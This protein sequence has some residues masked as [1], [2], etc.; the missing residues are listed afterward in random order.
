MTAQEQTANL[1]ILS[2]CL[3][4]IEP[5][6]STCSNVQHSTFNIN[7]TN[8]SDQTNHGAM[9]TRTQ[10]HAHQLLLLSLARLPQLCQLLLGCKRVHSMRADANIP[11][12]HDNPSEHKT[13]QANKRKRTN[14]S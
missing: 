2:R 10:A 13:Q 12:N 6:A 9:H 11:T 14:T 3:R 1:A 5:S 7:M 8:A 4:V